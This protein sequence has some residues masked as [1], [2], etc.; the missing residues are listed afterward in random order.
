MVTISSE[1]ENHFAA[2]LAK[3]LSDR[4]DSSGFKPL[5][6]EFVHL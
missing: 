1:E 6:L 3:V 2:E 4:I 5:T